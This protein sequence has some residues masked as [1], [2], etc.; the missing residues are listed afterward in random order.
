MTRDQYNELCKTLG[1]KIPE[2]KLE[3]YHFTPIDGIFDDDVDYDIG[4]FKFEEYVRKQRQG[5]EG[6]GNA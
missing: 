1:E 4:Y 5:D 2:D 6:G 3:E